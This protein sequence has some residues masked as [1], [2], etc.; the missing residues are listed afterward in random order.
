MSE[1]AVLYLNRATADLYQVMRE[2]CP[3]GLRLLFLES[4]RPE[5]VRTKLPLADAILIADAALPAEMIREASRL[6]MVQHQGVGYERI[7]TRALAKAGA[8]LALCPA[9]TSESVGEHTVL[10]IL[11]VLKRLVVAHTSLVAGKWWMWELRPT[12]RNLVGKTVGLIGFGRTGRATAERLKGFDVQLLAC[13]PYITLTDA[14]RARFGVTLVDRTTLLREADIVSLH[15]PLTEETR[16]LIGRP[17]LELMKPDAILIN[18]SR[19]GVIDQD[20]V[21]E[22]LKS[23]RIMGGGLDV[24]TPEPLPAGHPLTT[25]DNVVLTPH[26]GAGTLDA[27]R[28]KMRFALG[29]IARLMRG[30]GP[31]ERVPAD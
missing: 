22:A 26:V 3:P 23:R 12:T 8:I 17:E 20:A 25:L 14:E 18:T 2:E 11:A 9:G 28:M 4:D 27:F 1:W 30:E 6:K 7:D 31:L 16:H 21:Y 19:G 5:E 29:N 10:L 24:F 13:D 15:V